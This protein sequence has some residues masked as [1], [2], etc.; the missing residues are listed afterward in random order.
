M[1][2]EGCEGDHDKVGEEVV[3]VRRQGRREGGIGLRVQLEPLDPQLPQ[4][5]RVV[6]L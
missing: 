3:K 1:M 2:F 4:V 5:C 6:K